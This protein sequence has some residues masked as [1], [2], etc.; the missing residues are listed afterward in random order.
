MATDAHITD[1]LVV[2]WYVKTDGTAQALLGTAHAIYNVAT[3]ELP[4]SPSCITW[5]DPSSLTVRFRSQTAC[6]VRI[7]ALRLLA[8]STEPHA[9]KWHEQASEL[10]TNLTRL[11]ARKN[12]S[13][14]WSRTLREI[15]HETVKIKAHQGVME[16][17]LHMAARSRCLRVEFDNGH[18]EAPCTATCIGGWMV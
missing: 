11:M 12:S 13:R 8:V 16:A 14:N 6:S 9:K 3:G 4:N 5:F 10:E 1:P 17:A 7:W 2:G 18:M 15:R